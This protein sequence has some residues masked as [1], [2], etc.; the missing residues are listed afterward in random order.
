MADRNTQINAFL[1]GSKW[2]DATREPLAGD[3][4]DRRYLRLRLGLQTAVLMDA[5][6]DAGAGL[7]TFIDIDTWLLGLGLSAPRILHQDID[8]GLLL[9]E[10]LGDDLFARVVQETPGLEAPLYEAATDVLVALHQTPPPKDMAAYDPA[11]MAERAALAYHWY[12]RGL[13]QPYKEKAKAFQTAF[14]HLLIKHCA[15]CDVLIQR[16]YH[17]ENLLWLPDRQGIARVGLLDFQDAM[18]GHRAYDLMSVLQDARR[19]VSRDIETAMIERY[20]QATGVARDDFTTAYAVLGVQRNLRIIGVFAR[21]CLYAG[22]AHYVDLMPRVWGFIL[23][24]LNHPALS[25]I[26]QTVLDELPPPDPHLM[27]KLKDQCATIPT[28]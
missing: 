14:E 24:D 9:L 16:D 3:A 8:H 7:R 21:L 12:L 28:L 17:A 18:A 5:R 25:S 26:R 1:Q 23:R 15:Q 2:A 22:K 4:S 11:V 27:K 10:D 6:S 19:D 13:D 20:I